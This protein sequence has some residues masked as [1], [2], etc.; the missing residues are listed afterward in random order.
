[1]LLYQRRGFPHM[2]SGAACGKSDDTPWGLSTREAVHAVFAGRSQ[3]ISVGRHDDG[4]Q[5]ESAIGL[6]LDRIC[7]E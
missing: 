7:W 1:M 3:E 5:V 2:R 4:L 6:P